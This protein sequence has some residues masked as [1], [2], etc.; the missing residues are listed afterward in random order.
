M[1][2]AKKELSI[3]RYDSADLSSTFSD[4]IF[5]KETKQSHTTLNKVKKIFDKSNVSLQKLC[6]GTHFEHKLFGKVLITQ[7]NDGI[8]V[9]RLSNGIA[10][11][12][13]LNFAINHD[14]IIHIY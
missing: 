6:I 5:K 3:I 9:I 13:D 11:S 2:R 7:I 1:T 14:I 4:F 10:K 8:A 12:I